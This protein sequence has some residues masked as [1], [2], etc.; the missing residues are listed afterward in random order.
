M[1]IVKGYTKKVNG[2]REQ[3]ITEAEYNKLVEEF[4]QT[5]NEKFVKDNTEDFYTV[6]YI[7]CNDR[8]SIT[9]GWAY[10]PEFD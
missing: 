9:L 4:D 5:A 8:N 1:K 10:Y 2:G 7:F 6:Q 3:Y